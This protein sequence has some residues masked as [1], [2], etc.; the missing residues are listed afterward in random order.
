MKH[1][2]LLFILLTACVAP[3]QKTDFARERAMNFFD[4]YKSRAD[5]QGFQDLYADDLIFKD[6]IFRYTYN[7]EEFINFY[8]WP[9]PLLEKHPDY[10]EVLVLEE[11]TTTDS[12]AMGRGHFTPFY[13]DGK[14]Y[15]D[16]EH[17]RFVISLQFDKQ[18]KISRHIDFIEYPPEFLVGLADRLLNDSTA[19]N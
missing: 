8:N 9:D 15:D 14:L 11:L 6:V 16:A 10:P 1:C 13:Y 12:T 3:D 19:V 4:I 17:M 5:W 7:K 2:L 18:G